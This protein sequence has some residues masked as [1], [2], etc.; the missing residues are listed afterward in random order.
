[1]NKLVRLGLMDPE[2]AT[3]TNDMLTEKLMSHRVAMIAD[4]A[5]GF[6]TSVTGGKSPVT[7]LVWIP[8]PKVAGADKIGTARVSNPYGWGGWMMT[9]GCRDK[10]A[11]AKAADWGLTKGEH[12]YWTVLN[13]PR[14]VIWD[15][16]KRGEPY[17]D[18]IDPEFLEIIRT[19]DTKKLFGEMGYQMISQ[20]VCV[21]LDPNFYSESTQENLAWIFGMHEFN[22]KQGYTSKPQLIYNVILSGDGAWAQYSQIIKDLDL[23]YA[24]KMIGAKNEAE[25]DAMWNEYQASLE[26]MGHFSEVKAEYIA[27][28]EAQK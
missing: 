19:N 7:D 25:F 2:Y 11:I 22:D 4:Q 12:R 27:A 23:Q 1:M 18:T 6:W 8:F 20:P 5:W 16:S 24:A 28:Y 26:S 14:G 15:W 17:M 13:G 10:E 3:Q 9:V 21:D